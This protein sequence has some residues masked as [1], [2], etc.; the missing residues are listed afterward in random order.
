M[1]QVKQI[2]GTTMTDHNFNRCSNIMKDLNANFY[3]SV[4]GTWDLTVGKPPMKKSE[5]ISSRPI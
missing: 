4:I 1:S 5:T 3:A 2:E